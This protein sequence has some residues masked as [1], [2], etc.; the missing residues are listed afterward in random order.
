VRTVEDIV[1]THAAYLRQPFPTLS[2][3]PT[4]P[5]P[6]PEPALPIFEAGSRWSCGLCKHQWVL[7]HPTA[8]EKCPLCSAISLVRLSR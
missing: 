3:E 6:S 7:T 5:T 8:V 4:V 2:P 1:G